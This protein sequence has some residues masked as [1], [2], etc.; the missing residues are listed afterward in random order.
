MAMTKDS[1]QTLA[2]WAK[3]ESRILLDKGEPIGTPLEQQLLDAWETGRPDLAASMTAWGA[4]KA[5]A[6]VLADRI[7]RQSIEAMSAGM[8]PSDANLMAWSDWAMLDPTE[9]DPQDE[10]EQTI[11]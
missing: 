6:H 1:A 11:V 4:L 9:G 8:P 7:A 10:D 3:T 5:L 2:K